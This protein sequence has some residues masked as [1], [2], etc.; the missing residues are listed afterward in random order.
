MKS[1]NQSKIGVKVL[2]AGLVA[3]IGALVAGC[4]ST[5]HYQGDTAA[6]GLQSAAD[7]V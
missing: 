2:A 4:S 5:S 1:Q 6:N 7:E 3:L